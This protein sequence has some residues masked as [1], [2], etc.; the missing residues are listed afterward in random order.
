M[1]AP[2]GVNARARRRVASLAL[3][4]LH[5]AFLPLALLLPSCGEKTEV[6]KPCADCPFAVIEGRVIGGEGTLPARVRAV[7]VD[8]DAE[9]TRSSFALTDDQGSY[10]L[11]VTPGEYRLEVRVGLDTG[12]EA[13]YSWKAGKLSSDGPG[14]ILRL[15][16]GAVARHIDFELGRLRADVGTPPPYRTQRLEMVIYEVGSDRA[17]G[18]HRRSSDASLAFDSGP[19]PA[20]AYFVAFE[21]GDDTFWYPHEAERAGAAVVMVR[22]DEDTHLSLDL[23][24]PG[25]LR[26]RVIGSWQSMEGISFPSVVVFGPDSTKSLMDSS[27]GADGRFGFDVLV[28]HELRLRVSIAG[29]ARWLGGAS[30]KRAAIVSVREGEF[31]D[32]PDY[33]ESGL[34]IRVVRPLGSEGEFF[35]V[36]A[37]VVREDGQLVAVNS[38]ELDEFEHIE[39]P[40]LTTGSYR[41][42]LKQSQPYNEDFVGQWFDGADSLSNSQPVVLT[43][44]GEVR[45]VVFHPT[46]GARIPLRV[47]RQDGTAEEGV[48]IYVDDANHPGTRD[49]D[50]RVADA[51]T[52][53]WL[54]GL[55]TGRWYVGFDPLTGPPIWY[56][57]TRVLLEA[58][59]IE[60]VDGED[61]PLIEWGRRP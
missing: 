58:T 48:R 44:E 43:H 17:A 12:Y 31:A 54:R 50:F 22:T 34:R 39:F 41:V 51:D 36:I 52:I 9:G 49:S 38:A 26:G 18:T 20:G 23:P 61:T 11:L 40:N 42:Q 21:W 6:I 32:A 56:P 5:L 28:P 30:F 19:L 53:I 57:G 8:P 46:R 3:A 35:G 29:R 33:V 55:P 60:V 14:S 47:R 10:R 24:M 2:V 37:R 16:A 1:P 4:L 15:E 7:A 59:P 45:E 27:V 25:Q 13:G